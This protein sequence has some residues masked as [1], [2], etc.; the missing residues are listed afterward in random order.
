MEQTISK[1]E[2]KGFSGNEL[3]VFAIV[4]IRHYHCVA[5]YAFLQ[6]NKR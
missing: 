3:K 5:V 4:A 2:F 1:K 6:W